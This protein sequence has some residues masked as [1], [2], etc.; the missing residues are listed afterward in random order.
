VSTQGSGITV[1]TVDPTNGAASISGT[2]VLGNA[3][4][5]GASLRRP[6]LEP[7]QEV[8]AR[9]PDSRRATGCLNPCGGHTSRRA[10]VNSRSAPALVPV[11]QS[12]LGRK[13][14]LHDLRRLLLRK[15]RLR[16]GLLR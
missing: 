11:I 2:V 6:P 15:A 3:L 16:S 13:L 7:E 4:L 8:G 1:V 14:R 5:F 9:R 10:R 12:N